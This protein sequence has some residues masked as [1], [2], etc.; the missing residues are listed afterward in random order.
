MNTV[1]N[2]KGA[3]KT[4]SQRRLERRMSILKKELPRERKW[5]KETRVVKR[6]VRRNRWALEHKRRAELLKSPQPSG[7][8][9][10]SDLGLKGRVGVANSTASAV[11]YTRSA[12][13]NFKQGNYAQGG[14]ELLSSVS[15]V[16]GLAA[17]NE[18]TKLLG[19]VNSGV[20][21]FNDVVHGGYFAY[22]GRRVDAGESASSGFLTGMS[23]IPGPVGV[24]GKAGLLTDYCMKVSGADDMMVRTMTSHHQ[25]EFERIDR[26]NQGA[27]AEV[28]GLSKERIRALHRTEPETLARAISGYKRAAAQ[29]PTDTQFTEDQYDNIQRIY[30]AL[31]RK[32]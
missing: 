17:E 23:L 27:A 13:H 18:K 4:L 5:R 8:A 2:H 32:Y 12:F 29:N 6:R 16:A 3:P 15:S 7:P 14:A 9:T 24:A 19:H 26:K 30:D 25:G 11:T 22:K 28:R 10:L 20:S 21:I 1:P 31:D